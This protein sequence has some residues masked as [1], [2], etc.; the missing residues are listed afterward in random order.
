MPNP[1]FQ[2]TLR[3]RPRKAAELYVRKHMA[4]GKVKTSRERL[5]VTY[6]EHWQSSQTFLKLGIE[7]PEGS[8]HQFLGSI[9][10]TAFSLEA[11][12][13]H[14]GEAIFKSWPELEKLTPK[15]KVNLI[16]EK[17]GVKVDYG[18]MPWQIIPEI[19]G[20]R[21]KIAHGKN[22]LLRDE[23]MLTV[24]TYDE[25]MGE[26][27]RSHWQSYVTQQSAERACEKVQEI[28]KTI[29]AKANFKELELF[30]IGGQSGSAEFVAD[31]E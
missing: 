3:K 25:K 15:G 19:I 8:Y 18:S 16:T 12:L 9:V 28:C 1:A 5:L 14:V 13:N 30:E 27:L 2:R 17:L 10:F 22:E 6:A 4:Q 26:I 20:V 23:R 24:D 31:V 29:W 7:N 11:F 21:N